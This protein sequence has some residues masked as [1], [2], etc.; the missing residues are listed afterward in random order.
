MGKRIIQQ[1]RGHGGPT[2]RS[3]GHRFIAKPQHRPL[4]EREKEG[5]TFGI[6]KDI[7]KCPGHYAPLAAIEYENKKIGYIIA[8]EGLQ[9]NQ[10]ISSG[11]LAEVK[12][13]NTLPLTNITPPVGAA[14]NGLP[15]LNT[16]SPA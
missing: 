1:A 9:V 11:A 16:W 12:P 5:I 2:Y 13:G 7:V 14:G 4:D 6:V 8:P 15:P 10:K 3:P